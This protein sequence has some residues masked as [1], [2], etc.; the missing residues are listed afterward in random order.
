MSTLSKNI[1]VLEDDG[2]K[3]TLLVLLKHNPKT[4]VYSTQSPEARKGLCW[5]LQ[6]TR[7]IMRESNGKLTSQ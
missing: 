5:L 6:A 3:V 7:A 4:A 1:L 2:V